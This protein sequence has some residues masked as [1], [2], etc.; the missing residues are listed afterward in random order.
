MIR[1]N[2]RTAQT[3]RL[4]RNLRTL[5]RETRKIEARELNRQMRTSIGGTGNSRILPV[6]G[7]VRRMARSWNISPQKRIRRR[8][9][10]P[11]G[12]QAR[13]ERLVAVGLTL[14][15]EL[16]MRYFKAG[17]PSGAVA[18][19]SGPDSVGRVPFGGR[20][21]VKLKSGAQGVMRKLTPQ[22]WGSGGRRNREPKGYLP[23]G[24]ADYVDVSRP[25]YRIRFDVLTDLARFFPAQMDQAFR[26][27]LRRRFR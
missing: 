18:K 17:L 20:F 25:A 1:V 2:P 12:A 15:A 4:V 26:K 22:T 19:P 9:L 3:R 7:M 8:I 5:P 16:P 14:F 27:F 21:E 13:P 11:R 10:W 24:W 6:V 23:I